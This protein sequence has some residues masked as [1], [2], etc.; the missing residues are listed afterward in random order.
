M[1][2]VKWQEKGLKERKGYEKEEILDFHP[3]KARQASIVDQGD[4]DSILPDL[5]QCVFVGLR[6]FLVVWGFLGGFFVCFWVCLFLV[7]G[8]CLF[9]FW[10]FVCFFFLLR[11]WRGQIWSCLGF[12]YSSFF[13][14]ISSYPSDV[15]AV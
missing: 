8:F 10:F 15:Y 4:W 9:V 2:V 6:C 1:V 5:L 11:G 13:S 7:W 3:R 14:E 12:F